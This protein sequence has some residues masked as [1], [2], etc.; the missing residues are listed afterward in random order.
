MDRRKSIGLVLAENA[1][2]SPLRR[3][4]GFVRLN[5]AEIEVNDDEA[6][7]QVLRTENN[8]PVAPPSASRRSVHLGAVVNM[9]TPQIAEGMAQCIKLSTQNK[10][11]IKNAFSLN[12]ID[13]MTYMVR[14][15]SE[16]IPNLHVAG[17]TLDVS[18]KIYALRVDSLYQ[19]T[20]K[21]SGNLDTNHKKHNV[22]EDL[23]E[24]NATV[25]N[26]EDEQNN[27]KK[28]KKKKRGSQKILT[29]IEALQGKVDT[30]DYTPVMFGNSDCQTTNM[31]YQ[32]SLPQHCGLGLSLNPYNDVIIDS[33]DENT[34]NNDQTRIVWPP[35]RVDFANQ[36]INNLFST[37]EILHWSVE[38]DEGESPNM[39][40]Q[41]SLSQ[42]DDNLAFDL[43]ASVPPEEDEN[44]DGNF[45]FAD[46]NEEEEEEVEIGCNAQ[47]RAPCVVADLKN[48]IERMPMNKKLEYSIFNEGVDI[49][50]VGPSHWK[51]KK[52][53][54]NNTQKSK[55][56]ACQQNPK[57]KKKD[58]NIQSSDEQI[59]AADEKS[60]LNK[61]N[62]TILKTATIKSSWSSRKLLISRE[63]YE[64][65]DTKVCKYYVRLDELSFKSYVDN[66]NSV[67]SDD[68]NPYDYDNGNDTLNYCSNVQADDHQH[69]DIGTAANDSVYDD[70]SQPIAFTNNNLIEAPKLTQKIYIPFSQRAKKLDV[71]HLKKCIWGTLTDNQSDKEN[72]RNE[73]KLPVIKEQ[74]KFSDI[75]TQLPKMLSKN[76]AED[77]S[78]PIAFVS[79]L[80]LA[81]EKCLSITSGENYGEIIIGS[82]TQ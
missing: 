54:N 69:D 43:D 31:L 66:N 58:L 35:L 9:S 56:E 81:N 5:T 74:K 78:F 68:N 8:A 63:N 37:F 59:E 28:K 24:D 26:G 12:M 62:S 67:V 76:D 46:Q 40:S 33:V 44:N 75:Y 77:L 61:K 70:G 53:A 51:I 32:A 2:S 39:S 79:L 55:L 29:T 16:G 15:K 73:K 23:N 52:L 14:N 25:E 41:E 6:E 19:D 49:R 80:H 48:L 21:M 57:R 64:E 3:R 1:S 10:I 42:D 18:A 82:S 7:R 50:W 22:N 72:E 36:Q 65:D 11:N 60:K 4:S 47:S 45:F 71:R 27:V 38:Q 13:F 30:V 17:T 34:E 20:L